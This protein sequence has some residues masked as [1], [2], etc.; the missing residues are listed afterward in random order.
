MTQRTKTTIFNAALTRTG[1]DPT[2]EGNGSPIWLALEANYP[3]IVRDAFESGEFPFGKTRVEL[4]S[5]ADGRFGYEDA[6]TYPAEILHFIDV[7]LDGR[8]ASDLEEAWDIDAETREL[9][10]DAS[11]RK[12]EVEGIKIGLEYTWSAKFALGIQ[13]RLEAVIRDVEEE[14]EEASAKDG[15]AGYALMAAGVKASKNRSR[16]KIRSGGRLI[17]AHRGSGRG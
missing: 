14:T 4:T 2:S 6:F 11:K 5:R 1:N 7:Y 3:D 9:M 17:R 13:R 15:E 8:R 10:I 16:R 12:V